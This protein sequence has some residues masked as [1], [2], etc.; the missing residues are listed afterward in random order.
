M[1]KVSLCCNCRAIWGL[2][3][4]G[5]GSTKP[6]QYYNQRIIFFHLWECNWR[7]P[8]FAKHTLRG[9]QDGTGLWLFIPN[10]SWLVLASSKQTKQHNADQS[11]WSTVFQPQ[12]RF[13]AKSNDQKFRRENPSQRSA[14]GEANAIA[15]ATLVSSPASAPWTSQSAHARALFPLLLRQR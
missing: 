10:Y 4:P 8:S 12:K 1:P 2:C 15:K 7:S 3:S 11:L 6:K 14:G 5:I 13:P 9:L